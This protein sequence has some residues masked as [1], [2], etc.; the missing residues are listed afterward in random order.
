MS[1]HEDCGAAHDVTCNAPEN[2]Q[3]RRRALRE[4]A[5]ANGYLEDGVKDDADKAP[6]DLLPW[7]AILGA[8]KVF[9]FG[10][11]KYSAW[12]WC[13]LSK[14]RL[15][16]AAVRHLIAYWIGEDLDPETKLP[17]LDHALCCVM[18]LRSTLSHGKDDRPT[19][20]IDVSAYGDG[21][22]LTRWYSR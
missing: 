3:D 7:D 12:N 6:L 13:G 20:A 21:E 18:M 4:A 22:E 11:R 17:H 10:R 14:S 16:G 1:D 19:R 5:T 8:A 15:F 2:D 9:G